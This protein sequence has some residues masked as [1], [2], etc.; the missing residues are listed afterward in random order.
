MRDLKLSKQIDK[1]GFWAVVLIIV[2][3][4]VRS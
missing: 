4:R 1:I 2:L 3:S